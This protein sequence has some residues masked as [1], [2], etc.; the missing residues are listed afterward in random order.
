MRAVSAAGWQWDY[1]PEEYYV[2]CPW[3]GWIFDIRT[4]ENPDADR[5]RVPTYDVAVEDGE[6]FVVR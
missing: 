4:G 5:Y 2:H 3:H 6:I 1:D